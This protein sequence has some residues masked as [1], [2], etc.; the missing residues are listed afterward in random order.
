MTGEDQFHTVTPSSNVNWR[1]RTIRILIAL[2]IVAIGA[3]I[4]RGLVATAPKTKKRP[5]VKWVPL[6]EVQTF[7]PG[8]Q[9]VNVKAMGTVIPAKSVKLEA[10]VAGQVIAT[11]PEFVDGGF[12]KQG[13]LLVQLDNSDYRLALAQRKSDLVNAQYALALEQGRQQVARREWRLLND[14]GDDKTEAN[15]ALRKPHLEKAEADVAAARAAVQKAELDLQRT[16]ITAPF[17]A[18]VRSRSVETGSQV[19]PQEPLAEL[20]GTDVYWIQGTLPVDHLD[21][22]FIPQDTDQEGSKAQIT[23]SA[24]HTVEGKVVRLLGDLTEQGRMAKIIV[25]VNDPLGRNLVENTRPP[26][27]I[28]EYVGLKIMGRHL[29]NVFS[30]PRTAL[31]DDDTVWLLNDQNK[32]EI[33]KVKPEWRD[34]DHVLL[35]NSLQPGDRLVVSDLPAPIAGMEL[36]LETPQ[37]PRKASDTAPSPHPQD[38]DNG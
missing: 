28:G 27:L 25:A 17:N 24:G 23:Y 14:G 16:R 19:S 5:P 6:V 20:I 26:L 37:S 11:H 9:Q 36:R 21:W 35:G 33:K 30:V 3:L 10:R 22:I 18:I 7:K 8:R 12:V 1:R 34:T 32:L 29:D 15:L 4:A 31:R 38:N 13:D 2:F